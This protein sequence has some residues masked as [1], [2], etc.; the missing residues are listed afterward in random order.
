MSIPDQL[1]KDGIRFVL[2]ER[3][4][5]KPFQQAWQTKN[6]PF[7][8][9]ELNL[10]VKQGG[11]YGVMGGGKQNLLIVDF[12]SQRVQDELLSKL[13]PTLTV[14]TGSGM[15][16]KYFFSDKGES[17]K[18][19]DG[20]MNTLVD[21]QGEGK[22]AV[23]PGSTHPNGNKYEMID[24]KPIA[25]ITYAELQAMILPYDNKPKKVKE[26]QWEAPK[27]YRHDDLLEQLKRSI[28]MEK[29]LADFGVDTAKNPTSCPFHSSKGGKCLSFNNEVAHC[30][31]CDGGWNIF[32]FTQEMKKC[33]FKAA[34][35]WLC[36]KY[37][38]SEELRLSRQ[39]FNRLASP[40]LKEAS[41]LFSGKLKTAQDFIKI[42]PLFFDEAGLW[43]LWR[44]DQKRW[45][46]V[47]EV[48]ITN[49]LSNV[50]IETINSKE[51]NEILQA[52]KQVSR[53][54]RPKPLPKTWVQ[55]SDVIVDIDN[56]NEIPAS[57]EYFCVNPIPW[58]L[59]P[60]R[61]I[62]TP[63]MDKLF[64]EWV[65]KDHVKTLHQIIAF[66][67]LADYPIHRL[68]C[69]IGSGMNGKSCY[70]RLVENFIGKDNLC[71]TELDTL[72]S[73]RFEVTRLHKKLVCMMGET[74]FNELV[75]TS[76]LKKLT[77]QDMIGFEYKNK[78]PFEDRNYAKILISTNNLPETT[79][80]TTGFYRRWLII[81]FPNTFSEARDVLADIPTEEYES[82]A[83]K[84]IFMLKDLLQD[85]KFHNE[86]DIEERQRNY[87]D[88]SNPIDKF[89]K[90]NIQLHD[91]DSSV[92]SWEFEKKLNDWC[93][94]N[95]F[96]QITD[97]EIAKKMKERGIEQVKP[98][99][100]W[101]SK[102]ENKFVQRQVRSWGGM[103]WK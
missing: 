66:C 29:L 85:R 15:M 36:D 40:E 65:G 31:H 99:K 103:A 52:L 102:E 12:D 101:F 6:I 10:H 39:E 26:K 57:P 47:D 69:F 92:P 100:S 76:M 37:D 30:F 55:F 61:F 78:N 80:K 88:K 86:G 22:Q 41:L 83:V 38:F 2:L 79:D 34:L 16:H 74:N 98:Y 70:M 60:Q 77:G 8:D 91:P 54:S 71:S 95:R 27:E 64:E 84:S 20:E 43:W 87:E 82:L 56:G 5:K 59:H 51:R 42:Q 33:D 75:R 73:S 46:I 49:L 58:R 93:K 68:F 94:I 44:G 18:I 25:F 72:L 23:G 45:M 89:I 67:M 50:R 3:G 97:R 11:N 32:S 7:N 48:E 81:D 17:F 14:K 21:V 13:P 62:E 90:E 28:G 35:E 24:D 63:V 9:L 19:F 96:R 53:L 1:C 4:S